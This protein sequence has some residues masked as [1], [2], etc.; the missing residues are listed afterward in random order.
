VLAK[1]PQRRKAVSKRVNTTTSAKTVNV[2][3]VHKARSPVKTGNPIEATRLGLS[4]SFETHAVHASVSV[5][6]S[7]TSGVAYFYVM[8]ARIEQSSRR[9]ESLWS[10]D[11]KDCEKSV[12]RDR[13][14]PITLEV[15]DILID[16][17]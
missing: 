3:K 17:I 5:I 10:N 14:G 6:G 8:S 4:G 12:V 1:Q 15:W 9:C 13:I 2:R 7:D 16:L 11:A